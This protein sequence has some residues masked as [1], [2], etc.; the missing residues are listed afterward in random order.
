MAMLNNQRVYHGDIMGCFRDD[1]LDDS[2]KVAVV[3]IQWGW[4]NPL[5]VPALKHYIGRVRI[6]SCLPKKN[7]ASAIQHGVSSKLAINIHQQWPIDDLLHKKGL[8]SRLG[9]AFV[10]HLTRLLVAS[11]RSG[12][13]PAW[14]SQ[15][16]MGLGWFCWAR[17]HWRF[18]THCIK[19]SWS[20]YP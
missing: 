15:A 18:P 11:V 16:E 8:G 2:G 6:I 13:A 14:I 9:I 17:F 10:H 20:C 19:G 5:T 4:T 12:I 7:T 1:D 3:H